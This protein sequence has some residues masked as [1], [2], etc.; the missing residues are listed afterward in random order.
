MFD[1]PQAVTSESTSTTRTT[2]ALEIN[3]HIVVAIRIAV[4]PGIRI[5]NDPLGH[6]SWAGASH[7][8]E[9]GQAGIFVSANEHA[10]NHIDSFGRYWAALDK[11]WHAQKRIEPNG[12]FVELHIDGRCCN[13]TGQHC[14][15]IVKEG[16]WE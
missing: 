1:I 11:E 10:V 5:W 12:K 3:V 7:F 8:M 14:Q 2:I 16:E 13:T 6:K 9:N 4:I 15:E